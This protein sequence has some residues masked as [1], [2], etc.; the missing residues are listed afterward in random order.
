[1]SRTLL[2]CLLAA[3]LTFVA[4]TAGAA[5]ARN[6]QAGSYGSST[7]A[8]AFTPYF[9]AGGCLST[10]LASDGRDLFDQPPAPYRP[11]HRLTYPNGALPDQLR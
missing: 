5:T 9:Q 8:C 10:Y 2:P 7:N 4:G 6:S 1:M 11:G 3:A